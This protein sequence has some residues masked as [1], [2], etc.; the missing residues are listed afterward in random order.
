MP[1]C[2]LYHTESLLKDNKLIK[3]PFFLVQKLFRFGLWDGYKCNIGP[4][5]KNKKPWF[6][7]KN[8]SNF[9]KRYSE[10]HVTVG[11]DDSSS[12]S[13]YKIRGMVDKSDFNITDRQ[14][15]VVAEVSL[16]NYTD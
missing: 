11:C 5:V 14:G 6:Q 16:L 9:L 4:K 7:V 13:C 10:Y 8:C 15:R 1:S 3:V 12:I 2:L